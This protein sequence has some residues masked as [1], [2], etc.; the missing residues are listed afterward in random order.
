MKQ[1]KPQP[2]ARIEGGEVFPPYYSKWVKPFLELTQLRFD[3]HSRRLQLKEVE[4]SPVSKASF[5]DNLK[6]SYEILQS[7]RV[8]FLVEVLRKHQLHEDP[9]HF[10]EDI[11]KYRPE[12]QLPKLP[13]FSELLEAAKALTHGELTFAGKAKVSSRLNKEIAELEQRISAIVEKDDR[14]KSEA[15]L[16]VSAWK[17]KQNQYSDPINPFGV[18]LGLSKQPE[19]DAWKRLGIG[20][21]INENAPN[22]AWDN[23]I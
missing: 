22:R 2:D 15:D 7:N 20:K 19:Q 6:K 12:Y 14:L 16:F 5:H 8:K 9:L 23:P 21:Y 18:D 1:S 11:D 17:R 3:V 13:E 10:L 4:A